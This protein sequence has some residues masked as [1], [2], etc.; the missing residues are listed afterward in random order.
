MKAIWTVLLIL[1]VCASAFALAPAKMS[2]QGVLTNAAGELVADGNYSLAL[3]LYDVE[4]AGTALWTETQTAAVAGG[5][6]NV[7]LGS[8]TPIALPFDKPYY[9]GVAVNASE[10]LAP[11]T[12][13]TSAAYALNA[14]VMAWAGSG[15]TTGLP[16]DTWINYAGDSVR[17]ECPGPGYVTIQSTV[18]MQVF[19]AVGTEDRFELCHATTI[20]GYDDVYWF[21]AS[22][23]IPSTAVAGQYNVTVPVQ[24]V[25]AVN[26]AGTYTYYLNGRQWSGTNSNSQFWYANTV[27]TWYPGTP[28][29][30]EMS[31]MAQPAKSMPVGR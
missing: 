2:Y 22:H 26:A 21:V 4:T 25:K 16:V 14:P 1:V 24:S 8:V 6:F 7:M 19:H 20:D 31:R 9:L 11:R 23:S 12:L 17:I 29:V 30:P 10:E 15:A 18:W 27:A 5:I 3:S 28:P 13:L